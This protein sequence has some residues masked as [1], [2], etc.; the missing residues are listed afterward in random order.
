MG[1][2]LITGA[3]SGM[4]YSI[5]LR[6]ARTGESVALVSRRYEALA[7]VAEEIEAEGGRARPVACD[8]TD[9]EQ[10]RAAVREI[11]AGI[12]P[13]TRLVAN[14]GGGDPT[15]VDAFDAAQAEHTI[16]LNL[17]GLVN[18][19]D[20]VLPG[21]LARSDG[22]IVATGSLAGRLGMPTAAAYGA[23]KAG[24][25]HF[26]NSLRIDLRGQG[27]DI[28]LLEPGFV[29]SRNKGRRAGKWPLR[30]GREA[31]AERMAKAI[32]A[33]RRHCA[34]PWPLVVAVA[35]LR[36]LPAAI[37]D[38]LLAG[39]GR[40]RRRQDVSTAGPN[41]SSDSKGKDYG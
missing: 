27:V 36:G 7:S 8:V 14:A 30:V 11:E 31:A 6:L 20:A 40:K 9:I 28:T 29:D 24:V 22:H 21:M 12:G 5:A 3:S 32:V 13:V 26:M 37:S 15:F 17:M 25:A 35:L 1:V 19:V 41:E 2:T 10:V 33:R 18:C 38:R 34:F 16:R 4:G 23:A 39:K